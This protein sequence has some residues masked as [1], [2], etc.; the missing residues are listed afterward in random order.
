M[1]GQHYNLEDVSNVLDGYFLQRTLSFDRGD[2]SL[3][4]DPEEVPEAPAIN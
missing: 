1:T 4:N 2:C 3:L